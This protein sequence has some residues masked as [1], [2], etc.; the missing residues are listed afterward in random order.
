[1]RDNRA[2]AP[3]SSDENGADYG[4]MIDHFKFSRVPDAAGREPTAEE[5]MAEKESP[6]QPDSSSG[7]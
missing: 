2:A 4:E 7:R 6:S 3:L 1:M 5:A